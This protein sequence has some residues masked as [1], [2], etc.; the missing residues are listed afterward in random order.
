[1]GILRGGESDFIII[2]FIFRND[3]I[4]HVKMSQ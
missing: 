3:A 4:L 1:M 2:I